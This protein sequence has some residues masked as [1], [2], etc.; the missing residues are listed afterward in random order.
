MNAQIPNLTGFTMQK[1]KP[2]SLVWNAGKDAYAGNRLVAEHGPMHAV[3]LIASTLASQDPNLSMLGAIVMATNVL[4]YHE[5]LAQGGMPCHET[6]KRAEAP[7]ANNIR[8]YV[9]EILV[10]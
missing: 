9:K 6:R 3:N 5:I 8:T 4:Q 1:K 7:N 10:I 2:I